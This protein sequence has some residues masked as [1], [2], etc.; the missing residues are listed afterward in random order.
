MKICIFG[1]K[2][3]TLE[4]LLHLTK[5]K[6]TIHSLICVSENVASK[7][8]ISG[9]ESN[10][11]SVAKKLKINV[12]AVSDYS[13]SKSDQLK[14]FS[15]S[16]FD[17]GLSTGWQR[18]IPNNILKQFKYG[19]FGWHGS[20]FH[21]PNGRGRSPLN[22]SIRLGLQHVYHNCFKYASLADDGEIFDISKIIIKKN[23][24]IYDVQ[25]KALKHIKKSALKLIRSLNNGYPI[26]LKQ[27]MH[28]FIYF[29]KLDEE[30]GH[31]QPELM[32]VEQAINI[33]RSCSAPFPGAFL[34]DQINQ[35]KIRLWRATGQILKNQKKYPG[36]KRIKKHIIEIHMIDGLIRSTDF[37]IEGIKE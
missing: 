24:Y 7:N 33:I 9:F 37:E 35:K 32:K 15:E 22:W 11:I 13:L 1:N 34:I 3:S 20:G 10:L 21:L 29:P 6:I 19:I 30:S 36:E 27:T 12:F 17:L 4:L 2:T 31:I 5:N 14:I 28:P 18:I 23:D 25:I 26:L 16:K 8:T